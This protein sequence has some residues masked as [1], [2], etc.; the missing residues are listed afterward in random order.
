[1]EFAGLGVGAIQADVLAHLGFDFVVVRQRQARRQPEVA[2]RAA[3]RRAVFEA[4]FHHDAGGRGS[5]SRLD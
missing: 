2:Q 4:F 5:D 1:M 3:L